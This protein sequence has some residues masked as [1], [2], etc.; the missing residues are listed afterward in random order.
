MTTD[1]TASA[2]LVESKALP[3][4]S[5]AAHLNTQRAPSPVARRMRQYRKRRQRG[6]RLVTVE[7]G[8][9]DIDGL[10]RTKFLD[11]ED[12]DDPVMLQAVVLGLVYDAVEGWLVRR[13]PSSGGPK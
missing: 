2:T 12:R 9:R 10:V 7:L 13:R 4:A 6:V 3:T 11:E 1:S 5:T 8:V